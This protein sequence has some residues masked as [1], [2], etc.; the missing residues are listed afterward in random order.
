QAAGAAFRFML[1]TWPGSVASMRESRLLFM[2]MQVV[3]PE[4]AGT[5][6]LAPIADADPAWRAALD[7]AGCFEGLQ[8]AVDVHRSEPGSVGKLFLGHRQLKVR[9]L[10][11]S[12]HLQPQ[13]ELAKQ[14]RDPGCRV[15]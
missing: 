3:A 15:P 1:G 13:R 12:R 9:L 4:V 8:R 10:A 14:M 2:E 11:E 5:S 6:E 7:E